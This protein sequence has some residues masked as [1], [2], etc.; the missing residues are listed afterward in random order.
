MKGVKKRGQERKGEQEGTE[1]TRRGENLTSPSK[2]R[3][4]AAIGGGPTAT[5]GARPPLARV[6]RL[7]DANGK[8]RWGK[9]N[10]MSGSSL[11]LEVFAELRSFL[12]HWQLS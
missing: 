4:L 12:L 6:S 9:I 11:N 5:F 8:K 3:E 7:V 1:L 2:S 10:K